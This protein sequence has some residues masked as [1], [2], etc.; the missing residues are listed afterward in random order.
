MKSFSDCDVDTICFFPANTANSLGEPYCK[1]QPIWLWFDQYDFEP[2]DKQVADLLAVNPNADFICMVD[3]NTPLWLARQLSVDSFHQLNKALCTPRWRKEMHKFLEAFLNY[4][5]ENYADRIKAY[6]LASGQTDEWM[7]YDGTNICTSKEK[8]YIDWCIAQGMATPQ[9]VPSFVETETN[10]FDGC[11]YDPADKNSPIQYWRFSSELIANSIISFAE[12]AKK[13][14]RSEAEIGVFYGYIMELDVNR[15]VKCGHLAYEKIM[16]SPAVD[17]T[18][19]P[20]A[21]GARQ[22]G[23]GSGFMVP[24]G[25]L[26]RYGKCHLHECDQRTH[27]YNNKLTPFVTYNVPKWQNETEDIVGMKREMALALIN[28]ASLWW[29]D[30]WGGFYKNRGIFVN[31]K[32]MKQIW[33]S[34]SEDTSKTT[35]EI[36]L[37][38]DPQSCFMLNDNSFMYGANFHLRNLL[39]CTGMPFEIFS[40]N[41]LPA[42][43]D[44]ERYKLIV[45]TSS[46][47]ITPERAKFLKTS[48]LKNNRSILWL[49][50]PGISNGENLQPS[51]VKEW[52]GSEFKSP[53]I[54]CNN[55]NSWRSIYCYDFRELDIVALR[56]LAIAAG[57]HCYTDSPEV[58]YANERLLAVHTATGGKKQ[59][60]LPRTAKEIIEL[61][62]GETVAVN[63]NTF[64]YEFQAPD[65]A[66]FEL[67]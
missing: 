16:Q 9:R 42:L 5:E 46:F 54:V 30:M 52:S 20:G 57:V 4:A 21:Y 17:F 36:A 65:T 47:E 18:I 61:Y 55:M 35:A 15:L 40:F 60:T 56:E 38:V 58:V 33:D 2:F 31:L 11:L 25:T 67:R 1:Y 26:A 51:R 13:L 8:A 19:S 41:D 64:S 22:M 62:S 12:H 45:F 34:L 28:H 10:A 63:S 39:N 23:E 50:A 14:I 6:V 48:V 7:D 43:A 66:L 37:V 32:K 59:I 3:L 44:L 49:Y 24:H 53:E 27:T 29:F